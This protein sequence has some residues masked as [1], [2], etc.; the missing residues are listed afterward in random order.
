M[1]QFLQFFYINLLCVRTHTHIQTFYF[2]ITYFRVMCLVFT[3][4]WKIPCDIIN[5][6]YKTFVTED[7]L[8][9]ERIKVQNGKA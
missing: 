5:I 6:Y 9:Y 2:F 4:I 7:S 3:F 1:Q 8:E